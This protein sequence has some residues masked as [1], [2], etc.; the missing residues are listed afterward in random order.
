MFIDFDLMKSFQIKAN[1]LNVFVSRVRENYPGNP[2]HNFYHG[3]SV[4]HSTYLLLYSTKAEETF[5]NSEVLSML[6]ASLCHDI[7]HSGHNNAFEV[8]SGSDFAITYNDKSVLE[9]HHSALT[10]RILR[11]HSAN[12]LEKLPA[13]QIKSVR[14]LIIECILGTDMIRHFSMISNMTARFKDLSDHPLGTLEDDIEKLAAFLIHSS[15]LAHPSKDFNQYSRWSRLVCEEF[16][17]QY[18]EELQSGLPTHEFMKGL[19]EPKAYYKN[20]VG[21]L[22]VIVKPLWECLNL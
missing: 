13:D 22:T 20:E 9:N 19:D 15:D 12:I 1:K 5:N 17:H 18:T 7:G 2:F 14:K 8:N 16:T 11:D 10:F 6:I 4:M 21:F 3:F